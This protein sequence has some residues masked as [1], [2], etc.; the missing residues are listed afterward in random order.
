M[1]IVADSADEFAAAC[2]LLH[3]DQLLW[4]GLRANALAR[5]T[6]DCGRGRFDAIVRNLVSQVSRPPE[7]GI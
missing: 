3:G 4:E 5:V 1:A 7:R 2:V 6:E